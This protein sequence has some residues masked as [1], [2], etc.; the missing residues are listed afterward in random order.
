[1]IH[2]FQQDPEQIRIKSEIKLAGNNQTRKRKENSALTQ[3][4]YA[5]TL[6]SKFP[7]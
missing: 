5:L 3:N 2:R 7:D 1:M 6:K 4:V